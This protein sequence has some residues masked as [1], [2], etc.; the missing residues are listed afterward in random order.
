[1]S[2]IFD[3]EKCPQNHHCPL[4]A[5]CPVDAISQKDMYS[6]PTYDPEK[7]ISCGKCVKSCPMGAVSLIES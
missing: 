5:K 1:M 6:L 7:C 2:L 4:I 3:K